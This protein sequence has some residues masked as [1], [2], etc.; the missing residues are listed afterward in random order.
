MEY[1]DT[2][3]DVDGTAYNHELVDKVEVELYCTI[4]PYFCKPQTIGPYFCKY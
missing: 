2:V 3:V 4:R 1:V